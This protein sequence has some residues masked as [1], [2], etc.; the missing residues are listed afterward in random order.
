MITATQQSAE[1]ADQRTMTAGDEETAE[2]A[3]TAGDEDKEEKTKAL[4]DAY[5]ALLK[6]N[7]KDRLF[8]GTSNNGC[9]TEYM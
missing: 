5:Q 1:T 9:P 4:S 6:M 7:V 3:E 2:T 8:S